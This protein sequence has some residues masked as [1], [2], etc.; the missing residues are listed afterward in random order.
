MWRRTT[1]WGSAILSALAL[2]A[3]ADGQSS[4]PRQSYSDRFTTD[5]PGAST[6][7]VYA[8]DY[9]NPD[10]PD[11]KPHAFSHLHLEL[12]EGARFDTTAV[13]QCKATD[14][15]LILL[16]AAACPADSKVG[17]DETLV[18]T[19]FPGPGRYFRVDFAFFNNQDELILLATVRENGARVV[20]RGQIGENTLDIENPL[21][22]GTPP[23]GAA[24]RSQRGQFFERSGYLTTPPTCPKSGYWVNRITYTYRDGVEQTA[25]SR[26]PCV[27]RGAGGKKPTRKVAKQSVVVWQYQSQ[28]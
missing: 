5:V 21:V 25:A 28:R 24:A 23:D 1:I 7:R 11:G 13:V 22:P 20:V 14:A 3:P 18:D 8:I 9:F 16:G 2:A 27:R 12:A 19:G 4:A 15:E 10:D 17:I 6:G 26:S